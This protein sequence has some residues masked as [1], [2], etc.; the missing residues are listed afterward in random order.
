MN[1][2]FCKFARRAVR[3]QLNADKIE[4]VYMYNGKQMYNQNTGKHLP[5][6]LEPE[7]TRAIYKRTKEL[8][9]IACKRGNL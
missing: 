7:S 6:Y 1:A 9:A 5:R 3:I 8:H 2:K 4:A